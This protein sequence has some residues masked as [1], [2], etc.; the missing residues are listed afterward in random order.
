MQKRLNINSKNGSSQGSGCRT[1]RGFTIIEVVLVLAIAGLIMMMV[2]IALPG[3]QR[4]QRDTQRK[5]DMS[6]LSAALVNYQANNRGKFPT[7]TATNLKQDN[8]PEAKGWARFIQKYIT[9]GGTESFEDPLGDAY[10]LTVA[11]CSAVNCKAGSTPTS[12]SGTFDAQ[13]FNITITTH[14][15]CTGEEEKPITYQPGSRKAAITYLEEG[16]G[17]ICVNI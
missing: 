2:F 3:L 7:G 4:S 1:K 16:G 17:I 6:R 14:A 12:Q 10:T 15:S 5:D 13:N 9:M 8:S 11:D